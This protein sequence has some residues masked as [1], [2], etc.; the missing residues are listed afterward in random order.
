MDCRKDEP[1]RSELA[2]SVMVSASRLLN[3]LSRWLLRRLS[4]N[5]GSH[6]PMTRATTYASGIAQR[7]Q[8]GGA[9]QEGDGGQAEDGA[10]AD[11]QELGGLEGQVRARQLAGQVGTPV[12]P[13]DDLVEVEQGA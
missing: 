11:G 3:A 5:R 13:L 9:Q 4:Q 2:M 6:Q 10:D 8:D 7:G 1:A 12:A